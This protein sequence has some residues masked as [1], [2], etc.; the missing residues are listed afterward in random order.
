MR[1]YVKDVVFFVACVSFCAAFSIFSLEVR[2]MSIVQQVICCPVCGASRKLTEYGLDNHGDLVTAVGR[3]P[4]LKIQHNEG[5][6]RIRWE[7]HDLPAPAL[8]AFIL[9][10]EN[11][12]EDA[13]KQLAEMP[14]DG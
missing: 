1:T 3:L 12:L 11:T 10:M 7:A 5:R 14:E 2:S 13:R 6:C 4:V 8:R 9:H